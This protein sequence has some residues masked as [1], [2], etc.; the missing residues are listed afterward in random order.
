MIMLLADEGFNGKFVREIRKNGFK[1]D[2][3][4]EDHPGI[5]D[6]E[7]IELAKKNKQILLTED[8]DFGEWV[9]AHSISGLT[10]IFL[11]YNKSNEAEI[12]DSLK[13]ILNELTNGNISHNEFITINKN[14]IR[15][16]RI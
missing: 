8:K 7:I 2:W 14:K 15:R 1:V 16:R 9:F 12:L 10:I 4:L 5:S 11:R 3:I 6:R 13:L